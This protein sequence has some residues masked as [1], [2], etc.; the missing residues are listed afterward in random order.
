V[1]LE[2]QTVVFRYPRPSRVPTVIHLMLFLLIIGVSL[3]LPLLH[4]SPVGKTAESLVLILP[5]GFLL[6]THLRLFVPSLFFVIHAIVSPFVIRVLSGLPFQFPQLYFLPSIVL[7]LL[8]IVSVPSLR[9]HLLWVHVG[10]FDRRVLVLTVVLIVG[11]VLGLLAW[12]LLIANDFSR[13]QQFVPQ[14]TFPVLLAY[15]IMFAVANSFFEEFVARAVMFDGF[16]SLFTSIIAVVVAQSVVF[17]LWHFNGFPGGVI[18]IGMVFVWSLFLGSIRH[19]S[20][21][22]LAPIVAH[23]SADATIALILLFVLHLV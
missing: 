9:K 3:F 10:K 12:A 18:G 21:G 20:G 5:A 14:V 11:S 2:M 16:A 6:L 22:M 17:S 19:L 8:V 13:F 23:F 7:Y 1:L 4:W 15:G